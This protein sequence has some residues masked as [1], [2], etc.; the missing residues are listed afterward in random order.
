MITVSNI[1]KNTGRYAI[2]HDLLYRVCT[3]AR[4]K[5]IKQ[6]YF[7]LKEFYL[8]FLSMVCL[9]HKLNF[10]FFMLF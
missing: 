1:N 6:K 9:N 8:F 7:C 10:E 5:A 3:E 4:F 2:I